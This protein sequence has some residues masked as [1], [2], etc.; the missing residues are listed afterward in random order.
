METAA[1]ELVESEKADVPFRPWQPEVDSEA[2]ARSKHQW[3]GGDFK[4]LSSRPQGSEKRLVRPKQHQVDGFVLNEVQAREAAQ[5]HHTIRQAPN[6]GI[7]IL[8]ASRMKPSP[9]ELWSKDEPVSEPGDGFRPARDVENIPGDALL[10]IASVEQKP[11]IMRRETLS[12][13]LVEEA[14]RVDDLDRESQ[15]DL[16]MDCHTAEP[17]A[18]DHVAAGQTN[19]ASGS[20]CVCHA[21]SEWQ[22]FSPAAGAPTTPNTACTE[23][24]PAQTNATITAGID[25]ASLNCSCDLNL[26]WNFA[27]TTAAPASM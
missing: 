12:A 24:C 2:S 6:A 11:S 10:Q 26:Y 4:D 15:C 20:S 14:S 3:F 21:W 13:K 1:K 8:Q 25:C 19:S 27:G 7:P 5:K 17:N 22:T 23:G 9:R 18:V 16:C